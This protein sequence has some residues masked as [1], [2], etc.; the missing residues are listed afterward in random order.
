MG[1]IKPLFSCLLAP[2]G[3]LPQPRQCVSGWPA[4]SAAG[5][6]QARA[7]GHG[8]DRWLVT[9]SRRGWGC[10]GGLLGGHCRAARNWCKSLWACRTLPRRGVLHQGS[11]GTRWGCEQDAGPSVLTTH[12][13][14]AERPQA[15]EQTA[16]TWSVPMGAVG[17]GPFPTRHGQ[18]EDHAKASCRTRAGAIGGG[19]TA[20]FRCRRIVRI[21]S[22][23]M[24]ASMIRSAPC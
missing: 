5:R 13:R 10:S 24:M 16:A 7:A 17:D 4:L 8:Q 6:P 1:K 3:A 9:G 11:S 2:P 19:S 14:C 20:S 18:A 15:E 12:R 22:P 21:T 23:C